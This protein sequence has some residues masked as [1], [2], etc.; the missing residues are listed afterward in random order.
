M[1]DAPKEP[2]ITPETTQIA[3]DLMMRISR[4]ERESERCFEYAAKL[5]GFA[6]F[7]KVLLVVLGTL[8]AAQGAFVLVWGQAKWISVAFILF[9]VFTALGSGFDSLFKPAE[10]SPKFAYMGF[11]YE[12]L[13]RELSS[14][15]RSL[16][17]R[18]PEGSGGQQYH[19]FQNAIEDLA[20]R[21]DI[22]LDGLR[23]KEVA[24]YVMGPVNMVDPIKERDRKKFW[25]RFSG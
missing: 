2:G 8:I 14:E 7:W 25:R 22:K 17:R 5:S 13:G 21:V 18:Q 20:R 3:P 6:M 19:E 16:M 23:E 1:A 24:L 4:L 15:T 11:E 9:G 12:R 10:R